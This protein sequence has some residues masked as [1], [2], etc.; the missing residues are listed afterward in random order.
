[1]PY[2]LDLF[3]RISPG[4]PLSTHRIQ[5]AKSR[6]PDSF[7]ND[8]AS[9]YENTFQRIHF[10][11]RKLAPQFTCGMSD[12]K[13]VVHS[14]WEVVIVISI[15]VYRC[16]YM[17]ILYLKNY[18]YSLESL[19]IETALLVS[20]GDSWIPQSSLV[21]SLTPLRNICAFRKT[22]SSSPFITLACTAYLFLWQSLPEGRQSHS[23]ANN[24]P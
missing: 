16:I 18:W 19:L 1:M 5:N 11:Q 13:H 17:R 8:I 15:S 23:F 24:N 12:L 9:V 3:V 21:P 2:M 6:D 20:H 10:K 22:Q 7:N 4:Q 14:R